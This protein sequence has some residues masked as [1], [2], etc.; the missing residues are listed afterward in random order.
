MTAAV[1]WRTTPSCRPDVANDG[2]VAFESHAGDLVPGDTNGFADV[3]AYDWVLD[4]VARVSVTSDG[5]QSVAGAQ[6]VAISAEGR[7]VAF[8]TG[9][10]LSARD[11]DTQ[12][13]VY[14]HD[15]GRKT[16]RLVSAGTACYHEG[17]LGVTPRGRHVL[18]A[19]GDA[20][21]VHELASGHVVVANARSDGGPPSVVPL[22]AALSNDARTVVSCTRAKDLTSGQTWP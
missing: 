4:S 5:R 7:F 1:A 9:S 17:V 16:T 2:D 11:A 12:G 10:R 19:C 15:R 22:R 20:L 21:L 8:Y 6:G 3:F 18:Y 13:D 14:L